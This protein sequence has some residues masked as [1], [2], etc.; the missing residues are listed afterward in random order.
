MSELIRSELSK[1]E[2][3]KRVAVRGSG[4]LYLVTRNTDEALALIASIIHQESSIPQYVGSRTRDVNRRGK[5]TTEVVGTTVVTITRPLERLCLN[6]ARRLNPWVTLAEFP[7]I[8]AGRCDISW[9]LPFL[10]RAA[11]YSDDGRYWRAGYGSRLRDWGSQTSSSTPLDQL[12]GVV[13]L[14]RR[15]AMTRQAVMTLWDPAA[16]LGVSTKDMP[17]TNWLHFQASEQQGFHVLD[18]TVVMRSNDVLWGFSGVNAVNFT[19]LQELV[20]RLTG[21]KVGVYRHV[22][23]NMHVYEDQKK[24]MQPIAN[25]MLEGADVYPYIRGKGFPN[26]DTP[27]RA[28]LHPSGDDLRDFTVS[29]RRTLESLE[30]AR[31]FRLSALPLMPDTAH[32]AWLG[33]WKYFMSLHPYAVCQPG[34]EQTPEWWHKVLLAVD[35]DAW[36]IAAAV[37]LVRRVPRYWEI[38]EAVLRPIVPP[39]ARIGY[40][41]SVN[42]TMLE[43]G[44]RNESQG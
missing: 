32:Q 30:T 5:G 39:N 38:L 21:M 31:A 35:N 8:I 17:C 4:G 14:L 43:A 10:P 12:A 18:L 22:T 34:M 7:W 37:F 36:R 11:D 44:D 1:E 33:H 42:T 19:L 29:C 13:E 24:R 23:T 27:Q 25:C 28:E 2:Q 40:L 6:P 3:A 15:D 16:D 26:W 9:L 41:N 20:A